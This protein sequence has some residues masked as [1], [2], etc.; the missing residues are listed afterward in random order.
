MEL[1]IAG[2]AGGQQAGGAGTLQGFARIEAPD[3]PH[4]RVEQLL[5]EPVAVE[6]IEHE[7][8]GGI[9]QTL[10]LGQLDAEAALQQ[11]ARRVLEEAHQ[12]V[13]AEGRGGFCLLRQ[14]GLQEGAACAL[15][16]ATRCPGSG[17]Q[18]GVV[19]VEW[20]G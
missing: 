15:A 19:A 5:I 7:G 13:E 6:A 3:T 12:L 16:H 1:R 20:P 14:C 2:G 10:A 18:L 8:F 11:A 17:G 9:E 4:L